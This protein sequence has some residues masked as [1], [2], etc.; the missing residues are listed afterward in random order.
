VNDSVDGAPGRP[1]VCLFGSFELGDGHA[2]VDLRVLRP[3]ARSLLRL[4]ALNRGKLI[5]REA[6]IDALWPSA[7]LET[8]KRN[9]HTAISAVRQV[10]GSTGF[11]IDRESDSYR[12]ATPPDASWDIAEFD[13]ALAAAR[14]ARSEQ[15]AT[16]AYDGFVRTLAL[17]TD[18][19]LNEE[20]PS[21]WVVAHRDRYR[22]EAVSAAVSAAEIALDDTRHTDA[23]ALCERAITLDPYADQA[24]R[25][26]TAAFDASGSHASA[27]RC[28]Q[29][30][31]EM[32]QRLGIVSPDLDDVQLSVRQVGAVPS[33]LI[34]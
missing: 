24:W 28:R 2:G 11:T 21:E 27:Q 26:M 25:V 34:T 15:R 12:F 31:A 9:L 7:D 8:G 4:L 10:L 13:A 23:V 6:I 29:S 18:D 30:Y 20:G 32:Q 22:N 19:L 14:Q 17:Y 1:T 5:H 33:S 3:R 16:D